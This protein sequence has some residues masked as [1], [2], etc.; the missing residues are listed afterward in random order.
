MTKFAIDVDETLYSFGDEVRNVFFDLAKETGDKKYLKGAYSSFAEWRDLTDAIDLDIALLAISKVHIN[1]ERYTPF[2]GAVETVR[3]LAHAG[4]E[5]KYVTTRDKTFYGQTKVWLAQNKFPLGD[6]RCVGQDKNGH[7]TDCQYLIDDR[8]KTLLDFMYDH[9]WK[10]NKEENQRK[11][12]GLWKW[13]N[14]N[15][16]DIDNVY[17]SP[18]WR[19]IRYYLEYKN[20]L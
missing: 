11:A 5:I 13:Y 9:R 10:M 20:V 8:P 12:F 7:M 4:Y 16:T 6:I 17:L 14:R 3:D 15:L 2:K 1:Q 18:T 19:G